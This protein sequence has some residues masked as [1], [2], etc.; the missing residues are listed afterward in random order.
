MSEHVARQAL[1]RMNMNV[2]AVAARHASLAADMSKLSTANMEAEQSAFLDRRADMCTAFGL[3]PTTQ[4]KPFAFSQGVAVIPVH[5]TLINR[6]GYSWGYVTGY[7]FIRSQVAL[8]GLDPDVEAIVFDG[9]SYGGEAA[10]CFECAADIPRLANGKPTM[11]VVDSNCYSACYA[12]ASQCDKIVVTPSGGA[13]SIGVVAMHVDMSKYLERVGFDVTFVFSGDHKVDGNPYEA[14]PDEV[15]ADMKRSVDASRKN[16]A[17]LVASGREMDVQAVLDTEARCYRADDALRI[18]LIDAV[19]TPQQAVLALLGELSG[20]TVQLSQEKEPEMADNQAKPGADAA[21]T[22]DAA[23]AAQEARTAERARIQGIQSCD[24]SKGREK[25]A[26]HLAL[27]TDLSVDAAKAILAAS[28]AEKSQAAAPAAAANHF[29]QAMN[30]SAH[31]QVGADA[32]GDAPNQ[33]QTAASAARS[34]LAD[35]SLASGR[36]FDQAAK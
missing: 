28:P 36:K 16:F 19:A 11:F 4:S 10:G 24:E 27:N 5:G 26:S 17:E 25:L 13:G 21:S 12:L 15:R 33:E 18:G 7:N 31:P 22:Q 23:S 32:T 8:A 35:F 2:V 6:F 1:M 14:L 30:A 3:S 20:S 34:I 9:N 29:E